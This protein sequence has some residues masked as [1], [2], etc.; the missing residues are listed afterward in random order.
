MVRIQYRLSLKLSRIAAEC[1]IGLTLRSYTL[2]IHYANGANFTFIHAIYFALAN[3]PA[4]VPASTSRRRPHICQRYH[5][6][7]AQ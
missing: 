5:D 4:H 3:G 2:S 1:I 7:G 6:F